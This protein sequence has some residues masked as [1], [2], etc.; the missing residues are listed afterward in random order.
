M[1]SFLSFLTLAIIQ[2]RVLDTTLA[3]KYHFGLS[4]YGRRHNKAKIWSLDTQRTQTQDNISRVKRRG[5]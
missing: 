1:C 4:V 2:L 5:A 3:H